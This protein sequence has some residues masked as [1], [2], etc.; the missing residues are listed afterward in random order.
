MRE[1]DWESL[2][3]LQFLLYNRISDS[4]NAALSAIALSSMPEAQDRPPG[5]W[6]E[7]ATTKV[8][9]VLNLFTAW[10]YLIGY[11]QGHEIPARAIRPFEAN[12]L[13]GWVGRQLQLTPPPS[14][15]VNPI[16]RANQE[17][18]QEA[19]LLLYSAAFTQGGSVRLQFE[20]SNRG[21]HFRIRFNRV[22]PLPA[23]FDEL[24][25]Q[26]GDHWRDQDTYFEL[27]TARDFV[28][29]N[30]YEL[31]L[32][33]GAEVSDFAFF[34]PTAGAVSPDAPVKSQVVSAGPTD[35]ITPEIISAH[36]VESTAV[37]PQLPPHKMPGKQLQ[38]P[39]LADVRPPRGP[40]SAPPPMP[41]T[42]AQPKTQLPAAPP[43]ATPPAA[44]APTPA[45]PP[46]EPA[47]PPAAPP[48]ATA[49][50]PPPAAESQPPAALLH[51]TDRLVWPNHETPIAPP[52]STEAESVEVEVGKGPARSVI[53][54]IKLPE[55]T[56]PTRPH[57]PPASVYTSLPR[58]TQTLP[59][60]KP[61]SEGAPA[62]EP[63]APEIAA[64]EDAGTPPDSPAPD[65]SLREGKP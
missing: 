29:L 6:Q 34:V 21:M 39:R 65:T 12:A 62:G 15:A 48:A 42:G 4:L 18:L 49:H 53:V 23:T 11:K 59:A 41:D 25:A 47:P 51:Q 61:E 43:Q 8:S 26:F 27:S 10:S 20:A 3:D 14:V 9:N 17:T 35:E 55:P 54:P 56:P 45:V 30:G 22:K 36:K 2:G 64:S 33:P 58:E 38:V 63:D 5:F 37:L 1:P 50:T 24:L 28:R 31:M 44:T 40:S 13:L 60:V 7:R 19:L 32:I 16:L 46:A 57:V 52:V